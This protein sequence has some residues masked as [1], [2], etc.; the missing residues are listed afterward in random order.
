MAEPAALRRLVERIHL[1]LEPLNFSRRVELL[2]LNSQMRRHLGGVR[3]LQGVDIACGLGTQTTLIADT[4]RARLVG[5]DWNREVAT[6]AAH[7]RASTDVDFL[8]GD[9]ASLP[10]AA[11]RCDFA[12]SVCAF[13]HF[14]DDRAAFREAARVTRPGG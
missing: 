10:L 4:L 9:S 14:R 7:E 12:V 8:V 13:E 2:Y 1:R 6:L 3:P 11:A 5:I